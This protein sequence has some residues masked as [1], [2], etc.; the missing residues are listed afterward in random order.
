M[1]S[2]R[3]RRP[4]EVTEI[5]YKF[6]ET[7]GIP[8]GSVNQ[9]GTLSLLTG[10]T[11]LLTWEEPQHHLPAFSPDGN[12]LALLAFPPRRLEKKAGGTDHLHAGRQLYPA[13]RRHRRPLGRP[14]GL[15]GQ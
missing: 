11:R 2:G 6:D 5:M 1:G 14:A 9:L 7:Y 8:D 3:A 13:D 12:R 15:D 4:I 10:E